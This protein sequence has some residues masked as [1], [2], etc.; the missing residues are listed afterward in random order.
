MVQFEQYHYCAIQ[1]EL[2]RITLLVLF[3]NNQCS[4]CDQYFRMQHLE[5]C[6]SISILVTFSTLI[7]SF[8]S[9]QF[10][11]FSSLPATIPLHYAYFL[12]FCSSCFNCTCFNSLLFSLCSLVCFSILSSGTL[13]SRLFQFYIKCIFQ[14]NVLVNS[15]ILKF[16]STLLLS[17]SPISF[18]LL[19]L[20]FVGSYFHL[21]PNLSLFDS[22]FPSSTFHCIQSHFQF[23]TSLLSRLFD[24]LLSTFSTSPFTQ[25]TFY[26]HLLSLFNPTFS[27]IY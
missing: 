17:M 11:F 27:L 15:E 16:H 3:R 13:L 19:I 1:L 7:V 22:T 12:F 9:I 20:S 6:N 5:V 23:L 25:I 14:S 10:E 21:L 8:I 24:S 2:N 4:T 18:C 26:H